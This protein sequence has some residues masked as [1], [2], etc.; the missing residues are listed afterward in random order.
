MSS[1][2]CLDE[3]KCLFLLILSAIFCNKDFCRFHLR[4]PIA[5]F[6]SIHL[7][8]FCRFFFS[9][10]P[11]MEPRLVFSTNS[12]QVC[13]PDSIFSM[14]FFSRYKYSHQLNKFVYSFLGILVKQTQNKVQNS[15]GKKYRIIIAKTFTNAYGHP[16]MEFQ[17]DCI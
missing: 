8:Q 16:K 14:C 7:L 13:T 1:S 15:S 2:V 5:K 11:F 9:L 4:Q 12:L 3:P 17:G 10:I 6:S